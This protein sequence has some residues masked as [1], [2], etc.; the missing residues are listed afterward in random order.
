MSTRPILAS[1]PGK[2]YLAGEYAVLEPGEPSLVVAIDRRL[3]A[4]VLPASDFTFSSESLGM[5]HQT[6]TYEQG[7]WSVPSGPAP[8]LHFA[9]AAVNTTL[10]YLREC[11]ETISP[12]ALSL[13]G[14]LENPEGLKYGFGSSA[15]VTVAIVGAL[16]A[17]Y[18]VSPD[19]SLVF[20]LAAIAHYSTQA[21]GSG[22]DIAASTYGGAIRYVA[23]DPTWLKEQISRPHD[24][25]ELVDAE[26]PW[27]GIETIEWPEGLLLGVGWTGKP[28]STA[29]L[30]KAVGETASKRTS[31]YARFLIE[32]RQATNTLVA[33]LREGEMERA[34][35]TLK[36]ARH[37]LRGLQAESGVA[38]ETDLLA[39]FADA[40]EACGGSG[41]SS[42]AGG[43]DCGV[44][45]FTNEDD[46]ERAKAAWKAA[47]V[48]P[49]DV[50]I[51]TAGL[52]LLRL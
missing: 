23:F 2:L 40:A 41:K 25:R 27:L 39:A 20:K 26:W 36:A 14:S 18:G 51:S 12:F 19:T 29:H 3:H 24:L 10:S 47:G 1:A 45:L 9:K 34:V 46:R 33:A 35:Q 17:S 5:Q 7:T 21:S 28:A 15:A 31:A 49:L 44:A 6:A 37:A 50:E 8:R 16:L 42:G 48:E 32:A 11:A 43:G 13:E 4:R 52:Q 38:I 22:F 30:I